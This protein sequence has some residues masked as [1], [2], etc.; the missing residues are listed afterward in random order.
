[1][2]RLQQDQ[3]VD[4]DE[5]EC[6]PLCVEEFDLSDRNFR[7]CPCGY[8]ICQFCYNN[9]KTTMNG[10]CPACRRPYD[11]STIEWKTISPEEMAQHKQ[12]IAQKAKKN[13]QIRQKEAQKAEADSLSRKHLSGLRVVQK[14]LVYVTGLTP[15]IREDELL[16]T[17]RG[18]D[19]FGQYGKILK[20]V[21]S[22]AKENA[23]HQQSVGVYVTFARK[24][25]AEKCINAVD[26]SQNGE[27]TLRAQFGTTKYCSA[28]LRGETCN[29]RNCMFLHE[30][31]E[32]NDSF[33][34]QDLSMMNSIQTQQP[35][36][37]STSRAAPPAHQGPAVAAAIPM[38]RQDS[39]DTSSSIHEAPGL[40]A[41]ASW[42]SKA[43]LERRASRSTVASNNASPMVTN[44]VPAQPPKPSKAAEPPKKKGK[45]KEKEKEKEKE[46]EKE[47]AA[48][49]S[50]AATPPPAPTPAP[51]ARPPKPRDNGIH[52]LLKVICS[53]DFKFVFSSAVLSEEELKAVT[54]F[55]QLLD[56]NGGAKRRAIKE[57]KEKELA[58]QREAEA[59]AVAVAK[60][61]SQQAPAA[62]R[63]DNEATA[64]GSLQLGGEPEDGPETSTNH[65]NQH[66][67]APPGQQ[68]FG[69]SLFGQ[70]TPL[71]ED[72]SSLG[73][74][75]RGLTPQ[76]QQQLLLS[77]FKSGTQAT[78][79]LN[80]MPSAQHPQQQNASSHTRHT[81]RFSFANDSASASANVQ[82]V[83]NQKLMSQQNS[84]MPKNA[85]QFN[86]MSQ[87]QQLSGQFFTNVQGPPP[88]LKPTGTPP[89]S[90]TGMF[91]QGHGFA[92]GGLPYGA[93]ATA[94]NNNDAM[95]QDL[96]RSRNMD[97]GA[98]LADAGKHDGSLSVEEQASI[99]VDA[100]VNDSDNEPTRPAPSTPLSGQFFEHPRRSTPTIPPG[101]TVPAIPK[102]VLEE[103]RSRAGSRP[104]SRTT[105]STII[106]AVPVVPATPLPN[107]TPNKNTKGKQKSEIIQP[108]TPAAAPSAATVSKPSPVPTTPSR[109]TVKEAVV[110]PQTPKEPTPRE[111]SK[112][113]K[114]EVMQTPKSTP[115]AKKSMAETIS[116]DTPKSKGASKKTQA[117]VQTTPKREPQ[118]ETA[119]TP[120][121]T[122][123]PPASTKRQPPGKLDIQAATKLPVEAGSP[124][125]TSS[126][127]DSQAKSSRSVPTTSAG[128][129]PPSPAAAVTGSPIKRAGAP[130]TL[131]VV[132]TL[133]TEVP[134][135]VSAAS[136]PS[137]PQIP[138]VDKL[139]SRQ[140]SI[141]SVNIPG[142]PSEMISDTAS[143]TSTSFSR[144]SSPPPIGGKVGTAPVRKK[145]KSQAKK[146]RQE[147]KK[148]IEEEILED[149]KSD[150]EVMQAPI[151]G[152]KKK[153]KKPTTNAKPIAAAFKSQPAS[154]KPATV[155]EEQP[156]VPTVASR[157]VSSAKISATATPEPEPEPEQ[158]KEK[159]EHSAQSI[160]ADLQRTGELLAS[161][162]EFFKPLSSSLAHATRSTQNGNVSTPP[163]LKLHFSQADLEALAKKKPVRLNSQDAKPDSRTLI[164]PNGKFFWGLTEELE[165]KALELEKHI[166]EL[167]GHARFHPRKQNAHGHSVTTSAHSNDVLP[168]IATALKEAGKKLNTN[169]G[170]QMP[171]LDNSSG[172]LGSTNLPL[173]PVQGQDASMPQVPPPQQQQTPADAGAYLNQYVLP[174]TDNPPPN[175]PRPEMAAV[176]GAPGAGTANISVNSNRLAKA[177]KAV[178]EGGAVGST[179]IDGMGLMAADRLGGVFVQGLEALVGAGLGYQSSQEFGLDGNG[180]ITFG[181]GGGSGL[182]MQGLMNAIETTA[183]MGGYG[184]TRR[185]RGS[186]LTMEEAEQAMH[187][188]RREHDVLEKKL[189]AL[190]KKN[191]KLATGVGK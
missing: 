119:R 105:S 100:L 120:A 123:T 1:M 146:D 181:N 116:K 138:T 111:A 62:E 58:L 110:V 71:A 37:S 41:T 171:R 143:V 102:A 42:G 190:I 141:A 72:F 158:P 4:D 73:L 153:A 186:V 135:P 166:E 155:E 39:T 66:A 50:K 76:Q 49:A 9:I 136:Q 93:G 131:R 17:L 74:S 109:T 6:C 79:L 97:G 81:S 188:A 90:G 107:S 95:Y 86:P 99:N 44:A 56:P 63:E 126:K 64:G 151:I 94:R 104:M 32:D 69:G 191:K 132:A 140:A 162:L 165:N 59:E 152:R 25:D 182:D 18:D 128:S 7:P 174:K 2:S 34:R 176:G 156:E 48:Q 77:N 168:A 24:E 103:S 180:N 167:K 130:R 57:K 161:T 67:I 83:A 5:E 125:P 14:N 47:K 185:G 164:T 33:T 117:A 98:R 159:R 88:G 54:E 122:A 21:V 38:H 3:F 60:A 106:P 89:V 160:M 101:F 28:Y 53:P 96:L 78:G 15:T 35:S 173:P 23:Q 108:A 127:T 134:P 10:L 169:G 87:H 189:N 46:R 175:Q 150:V 36:Q 30:P 121:A 68:G 22:K 20:I 177:A 82:P 11:D 16:K 31:G 154:P 163:D 12:L 45:D 29:N 113:A 8:Q 129:V 19:Y 75:N 13:A 187:A 51:A 112:A 170:Q 115:D 55:P 85:N 139:R 114:E 65:L 40:P 183:G 172:L 84:M 148:Q 184:N 178:V 70:N 145:T 142:T 147:R 133:K 80:N 179:E 92:T 26:G 43:L 52:D 144:A 137:L 61:A 91:G 157:R 118:K 149:N 27:R 124:A